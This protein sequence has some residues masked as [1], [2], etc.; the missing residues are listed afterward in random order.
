[1]SRLGKKPLVAPAGVKV[2]VD[3]AQVSVKGPKGALTLTLPSGIGAVLKDNVLQVTRESDSKIHRSLHGLNRTLVAN[4]IEGAANGYTRVLDIDGVGFKA[5]LKGGKIMLSLG[6]S[7]PAAYTVPA[8][9]TVKIEGSSVIVSGVDKRQVG[10]AAAALRRFHPPEPYKG[11][12]IRYRGE[13]V[14]RK[15]GKT[16]A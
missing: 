4:M 13:Y 1:M 16:V 7:S 9:V 2:A 15:A 3:G 11:K 5:E 12:G 6:F 8:G 10:E 14:R